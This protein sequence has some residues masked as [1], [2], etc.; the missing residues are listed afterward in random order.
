MDQVRVTT[1]ALDPIT[2]AGLDAYLASYEDLEGLAPEVADAD[3][4]VAMFDRLV[5]PAVA[6]LRRIVSRAP[7][8]VVLLAGEVAVADLP[9]ALEC[10]VV[11]ILPRLAATY[12]RLAQ[13]IRVAATEDQRPAN[14]RARLLS[15][16]EKVN[17]A[18]QVSGRLA[19]S[20]LSTRDI[21]ILKMTA[22]GLDTRQIAIKLGYSERTV[23]KVVYNLTKRLG[24]RNRSQAVA[25]AIRAGLI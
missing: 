9:L 23:K 2:L 25:H 21:E 11:S 3:V 17:A 7:R 15:D 4:I 20:G 14:L 22:E 8:P 24:L 18:L 13:S 10:G 12:N 16:I 6:E 5:P 19:A 1:C